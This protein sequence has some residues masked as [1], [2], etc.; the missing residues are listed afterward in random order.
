MIER[1]SPNFS[2]EEFIRSDTAERQ[3]LDNTPTE[4]LLEAG[5]QF[6]ETY[7]EPFR[8]WVGEELEEERALITTSFFRNL[9][10]NRAVKGSRN[11]DHKR[12]L[13]WDGIIQRCS[14]LESFA[15]WARWFALTGVPYNQLLYEFSWVHVGAG[16]NM[17]HE[18]RHFKPS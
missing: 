14:P 2:Y 1:L 8:A 16:P 15:L 13:A 7:L 18:M 12:A 17:K 11:S 3:G 10:V 4:E 9:A 6:C 5:I